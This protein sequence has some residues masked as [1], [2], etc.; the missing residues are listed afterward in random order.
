MQKSQGDTCTELSYQ[1]R[2]AI[3]LSKQTFKTRWK[4]VPGINSLND[5]KELQ[6]ESS[7]H[8]EVSGLLPLLH[9]VF[10]VQLSLPSAV[11]LLLVLQLRLVLQ[12]HELNA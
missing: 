12:P 4:F 8:L 1:T 9:G 10:P 6:R 2:G 3:Y 7:R 11:V 5:R